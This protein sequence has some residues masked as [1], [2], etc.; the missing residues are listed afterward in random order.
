MEKIH[1]VA[2]GTDVDG[3][4]CHSILEIY[5]KKHTIKVIHYFVDYQDIDSVLENISVI[6]KPDDK[7]IIAI[8]V[9][10]RSWSILFWLNIKN[11]PKY[12]LG[13]IIINGM[14]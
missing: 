14:E 5:A 8:S 6:I 10:A 1:I 12:L 4:A 11:W 9:T 7:I 13:S 3:L 2:H